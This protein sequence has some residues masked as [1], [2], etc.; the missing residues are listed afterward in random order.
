MVL[1]KTTQNYENVGYIRPDDHQ[2]DVRGNTERPETD[3]TYM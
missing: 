1:R 3:G 2:G